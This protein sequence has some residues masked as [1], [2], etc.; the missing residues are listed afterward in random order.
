MPNFIPQFVAV[1]QV[2]HVAHRLY[3]GHTVRQCRVDQSHLSRFTL[4]LIFDCQWR[5]QYTNIGTEVRGPG[6]K[7]GQPSGTA[8]QWGQGSATT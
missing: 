7:G 4:S 6:S 2:L 1:Y 8:L 5:T 3:K